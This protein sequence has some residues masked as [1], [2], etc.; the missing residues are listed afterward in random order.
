MG[1]GAPRAGM[2]RRW[3]RA[4]AGG[5]GARGSV[6]FTEWTRGSERLEGAAAGVW[7]GLPLATEYFARRLGLSEPRCEEGKVQR[8]HSRKVTR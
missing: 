2:E 6:V 4:R 5:L 8:G 3:H 7:P 1:R